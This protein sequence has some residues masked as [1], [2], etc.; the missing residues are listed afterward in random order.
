MFHHTSVQSQYI[1]TI[2]HHFILTRHIEMNSQATI[3]INYFFQFVVNLVLSDEIIT[4]P[5]QGIE[6]LFHAARV[7]YL[8][9]LI[10]NVK[11]GN[12]E[13]LFH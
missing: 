9:I 3:L 13:Q 7:G 8:P 2:V 10:H 11:G 12:D 1:L 4:S 6:H 5:S